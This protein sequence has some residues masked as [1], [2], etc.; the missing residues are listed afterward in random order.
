MRKWQ[1]NSELLSALNSSDAVTRIDRWSQ[2]IGLHHSDVYGYCYQFT[3]A[4]RDGRALADD[5]AQEVHI[6]LYQRLTDGPLNFSTSAQA[7][8][9]IMKIAK[10]SFIDHYRKRGHS[11]EQPL[12]ETYPEY[13][14]HRAFE[15]HLDQM[16]DSVWIKK[17]SWQILGHHQLIVHLLKLA[18]FS[19]RASADMLGHPRNTIQR[20]L[21]K[22][23]QRLAQELLEKHILCDF[24]ESSADLAEAVSNQGYQGITAINRF[25]NNLSMESQRE[26]CIAFGA[27]SI[28][29]VAEL[30]VPAL[31]VHDTVSPQLRLAFVPRSQVGWQIIEGRAISYYDFE[32]IP[33]YE[34][35]KGKRSQVIQLVDSKTYPAQFVQI[36][37]SQGE[38]LLNA[39]WRYYLDEGRIR[40]DKTICTQLFAL[41]TAPRS[42]EQFM[43]P[44][45]AS[46]LEVA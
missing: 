20:Q 30:V 23:H 37:P 19:L 40:V 33:S 14:L 12:S 11:R 34:R 21:Q 43:V 27:K 22:A 38:N 6:K 44:F 45:Q 35:V 1:M 4:Y 36:T 39:E 13:P 24:N 9:Y 41:Y 18:G 3:Y 42:T 25:P 16:W 26:L 46:T 17:R 8:A 10:R 7:Q 29:Q 28:T 32:P 15:E 2:L 31:M 5:I